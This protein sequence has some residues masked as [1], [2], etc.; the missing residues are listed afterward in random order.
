MNPAGLLTG[1]RV[2]ITGGASGIGAAVA[3]RFTELGAVGAVID[4]PRAVKSAPGGWPAVAADVTDEDSIAGA[5]AKC[6]ELVGG[7]DAVV[8]SAGVVP[9]WQPVA[10]MDLSDLERVFA[11]NVRGVAATFKHTARLL[12]AGGTITAVASLNSWKGDANISSYAASKHA[13]LGLV[14]SAAL[15]L[16]SA[17]IRVNCVGPGPIATDALLSRMSARAEATG[18]TVDDALEMA[19][20]GTALRRLATTLDVA[21]AIAFLTSELSNGVTGQLIKVDGGIL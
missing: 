12:G 16:G 6:A 10:D 21:D 1:R 11:V 7:L 20:A 9:T 8:A 15:G 5:I 19:A 13:V 4:L 2:L 3:R 17:G 14:R 18:L